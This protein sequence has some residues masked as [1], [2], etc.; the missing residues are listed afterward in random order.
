VSLNLHSNE[1]LLSTH[2]VIN[3]KPP[4]L[5]VKGRNWVIL[6]RVTWDSADYVDDLFFSDANQAIVKHQ[7]GNQESLLIFNFDVDSNVLSP[8][9]INLD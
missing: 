4:Q 8:Q 3:E 6:K 2:K 5:Q 1:Q 7:S 9:P